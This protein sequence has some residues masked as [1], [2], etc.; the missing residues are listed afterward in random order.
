MEEIKLGFF[1]KIGL[2]VLLLAILIIYFAFHF[3]ESFGEWRIESQLHDRYGGDFNIT[4]AS[5]EKDDSGKVTGIIYYSVEDGDGIHFSVKYSKKEGI[6]EDEYSVYYYSSKKAEE[7]KAI[8]DEYL[9]DYLI[10]PN[11]FMETIPYIPYNQSRSFEAYDSYVTDENMRFEFSILVKDG[12]DISKVDDL[13][14]EYADD[15]SDKN[16][17]IGISQVPEEIYLDNIDVKYYLRNRNYKYGYSENTY[18]NLLI[19]DYQ[20][21]SF[22]KKFGTADFMALGK[23]NPY[24]I[25]YYSLDGWLYGW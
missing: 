16:Y 6:I 24:L 7:V 5:P 3:R 12:T 15:F 2:V 10:I 1:E 13:I 11:Y 17:R 14:K 25:A 8:T 19:N 4:H 21:V 22:M 18:D 9:D 23:N 20:F